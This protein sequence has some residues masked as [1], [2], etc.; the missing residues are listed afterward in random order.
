[1]VKVKNVGNYPKFNDVFEFYQTVY[2]FR[3]SFTNT[4]MT[5]WV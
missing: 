2:T 4:N 1:M 5:G 3:A